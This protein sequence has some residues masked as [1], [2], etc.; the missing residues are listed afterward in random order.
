MGHH[1]LGK[2][3][4]NRVAWILSLTMSKSGVGMAFGELSPI[5]RR[6]TVFKVCGR[7]SCCFPSPSC[8]TFTSIIPHFKFS[9]AQR[10]PRQLTDTSYCQLCHWSF[11]FAWP[12][13]SQ[14]AVAV[15]L[16]A[17]LLSTACWLLAAPAPLL[18]LLLS[19]PRSALA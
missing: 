12:P 16:W 7:M 2:R 6:V 15:S 14:R 11:L 5:Q 3:G 1:G 10:K 17:S 4:L 8:S 18:L 9:G 13:A 19:A